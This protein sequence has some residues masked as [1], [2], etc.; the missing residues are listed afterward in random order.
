MGLEEKYY[1]GKNITIILNNYDFIKYSEE[2]K[3]HKTY[4]TN[5]HKIT[6]K[7]FDYLPGCDEDNDF[8]DDDLYL[9]SWEQASL[10]NVPKCIITWEYSFY[11]YPNMPE[12]EEEYL[13]DDFN[14]IYETEFDTFGECWD[15]ASLDEDGL[16]LS[17]NVILDA[18]INRYS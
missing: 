11:W 18:E 17:A 8:P 12:E 3:D 2:E 16:E 10:F 13:I 9:D 6:Y 7:D 1:N 14:D 5:F 4:S 15:Y